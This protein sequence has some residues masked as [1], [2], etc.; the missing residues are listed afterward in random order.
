ME[1]QVCPFPARNRPRRLTKRSSQLGAVTLAEMPLSRLEQIMSARAGAKLQQFG[2]DAL[3]QGR[4][5]TIPQA[6][7]VQD[8]YILG[9]GDEIVVS[10]RGQENS[11]SRATVSRDGQVV[12]PRLNPISAAGRS[13]V[14]F[15]QYAMSK[16]Q[17]AAPTLQPTPSFRW[18]KCARSAC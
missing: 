2:Y 1:T 4:A 7:A 10:L 16:P 8:D 18:H 17:C 12:L 15:P 11:E 9:P 6:G 3:G 13:F 14:Q 5:V